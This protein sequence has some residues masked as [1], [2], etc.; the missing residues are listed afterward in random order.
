[1][2]LT[3]RL[4]CRQTKILATVATLLAVERGLLRLDDP[5]EMYIPE[6]A[7]ME[8]YVSGTVAAD[9]IATEP[10]ASPPTV[11]Q[12]L[13]HTAGLAYGGLFSGNGLVDEVDRIYSANELDVFELTQGGLMATAFGSLEAIAARVGSLPLRH[14]PGTLWDYALG[15]QIAG[16]C[17][18][19]AMGRTLTSIIQTEIFDPLGMKDAAWSESPARCCGR[20]GPTRS[21]KS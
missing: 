12:C 4:L 17:A 1:M 16:R 2:L 13:M 3:R 10:A 15:H 7:D 11:R 18:E 8:V 20:R 6:F 9:D 14:Q 5:V 19:V 21:L